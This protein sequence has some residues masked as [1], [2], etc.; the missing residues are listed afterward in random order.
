MLLGLL[1]VPLLFW[2]WF[3]AV[4]GVA[5]AHRDP[6]T[7]SAYY[8]P[9]LDVLE[10]AG[11]PI[12][13][14]EIPPTLRHWETVNVAIHVPLARGWE[15]QLDIAYNPLFYDGTLNATSYHAW[16][17][18]NGVRFVALPDAELESSDEAKLLEAGLPYLTPGATLPHWRLW[19]VDGFSGLVEGPARLDEMAVDSLRL[20]V[21]APG[22]VTVRV[23]ASSHW[24][25]EGAGCAADDGNGWLRLE[26]LVPGPQR[27]TQAVAGTPCPSWH[28]PPE[29]GMVPDRSDVVDRSG[30][31]ITRCRSKRR[32]GPSGDRHAVGAGAGEED[33]VV[34]DPDS[35]GDSGGVEHEHV[36]VAL[37]VERQ[38]GQLQ[39]PELDH[40]S[41]LGPHRRGIVDGIVLLR[42]LHGEV[43]AGRRR[44]RV[45]RSVRRGGSRANGGRPR[46]R[47][48][49]P[50]Q[51]RGTRW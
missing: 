18:E 26:G 17:V 50:P 6:S 44:A 36:A 10:R 28:A 7:N 3:P 42:D 20:D 11:D 40:R 34:G 23:R 13:R 15:R 29:R 14:V 31:C 19:S 45:V 35:V 41:P 47:R 49:W 24:A 25:V 21:F 22:S 27:V 48:G 33:R 5:F 8:Q 39:P 4:D 2:Q 32:S 38:A 9:L 43:E 12:G 51:P 30:V 46:R 37:T 1:A 16:L